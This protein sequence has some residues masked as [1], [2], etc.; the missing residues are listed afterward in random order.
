[1]V[2]NENQKFG[3]A[4]RELLEIK[5]VSVNK[6][7]EVSG[8]PGRFL[9]LLVNEDYDRLPPA[10]YVR[11]YLLK[12]GEVLNADGLELWQK[13]ENEGI[14][15]SG[16][17]DRLPGNRFMVKKVNQ[18]FIFLGALVILVAVYFS[19]RYDEFLG[20]PTLYLASPAADEI[21]SIPL[22]GLKGRIKPGD[23]L[24][25]NEENAYVDSNGEFT[26]DF[27]LQPGINNL[28]FKVK[29]FLGRELIVNRQV[30]YN[31]PIA[32]S[33][34]DVEEKRNDNNKR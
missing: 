8:V 28:E 15:K 12:I 9:E 33:T 10:P 14:K 25:I 5:G 24:K 23:A 3:E 13:L 34:I 30:I 32:T 1:M 27:A 18:R 21:A 4:F 20:N 11:G 22:I 16:R 7:A 19:L 6:L 2:N 17:L 29:R 26:K 31:P